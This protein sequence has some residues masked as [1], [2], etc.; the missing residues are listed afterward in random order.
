MELIEQ[1]LCEYDLEI[2]KL[3]KFQGA[4][5]NRIR[6]TR[7]KNFQRKECMPEGTV[8]EIATKNLTQA[9]MDYIYKMLI[10]LS[11]MA[12]FLMIVVNINLISEDKKFYSCME[13]RYF[14]G[15]PIGEESLTYATK[16]SIVSLVLIFLSHFSIALIFCQIVEISSFS[17]IF[18]IPMILQLVNLFYISKILGMQ[19]RIISL[20]KYAI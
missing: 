7:S 6:V 1:F 16:I 12:S 15:A 2:D 3:E 10:K 11:C 18:I 13:T 17:I 19:L 14:G 8:L 5:H 4:W 9:D 20:D